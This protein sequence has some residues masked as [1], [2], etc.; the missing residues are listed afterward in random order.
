MRPHA[1][2]LRPRRAFNP[3]YCVYGEVGMDHD[4][5]QRLALGHPRHW[6]IR[7]NNGGCRQR[8]GGS[9]GH[10][11][12]ESL[13]LWC[14]AETHVFRRSLRR[15]WLARAPVPLENSR[16][17]LH[18]ARR[19]LASFEQARGADPMTPLLFPAWLNQRIRPTSIVLPVGD[20]NPRTL[21]LSHWGREVMRWWFCA[22]KPLPGRRNARA[23]RAATI[24]GP[25]HSTECDTA[26]PPWWVVCK[27]RRG[28]H[29]AKNVN[30]SDPGIFEFI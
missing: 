7:G 26:G 14:P 1:H 11:A 12:G 29:Q 18:K 23:A 10:D 17:K 6:G 22:D 27:C 30:L 19:R 3:A 24:L 28:A 20:V 25:R 8:E 9:R 2:V 4:N 21:P 15:G 5:L 16:V 13:T